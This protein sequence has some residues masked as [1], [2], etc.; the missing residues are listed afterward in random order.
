[1]THV[2]RTSTNAVAIQPDG[3]IVLAGSIPLHPEDAENQNAVSVL[4]LLPDGR[5][6]PS[7]SRDGKAHL[8][9][10]YGNDDAEAV[11][12]RRGRIVVAGPGRN[13]SSHASF[14]VARFRRDGRVDRSFGNKGRRLV[15]F[16]RQRVAQAKGLAA[17]PDGRLLVAGLAAT[18]YYHPDW[19]VARLTPDGALDRGFGDSGRVRMAPGPFGGSAFAVAGAGQGGMLVAG[20]ALDEATRT[21][22]SHWVLMRYSGRGTLDPSFGEHGIV[23]TRFGSAENAASALALVPGKAIVVGEIGSHLGV[24]RYLAE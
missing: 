13:T 7:F 17:T 15:S 11:V 8:D 23:R 22:S 18:D 9:Y 24:A 3:R 19:A 5:L 4:R 16:G 2:Q 6:D 20:S 1:V 14:G 21:S 12:L 10:G